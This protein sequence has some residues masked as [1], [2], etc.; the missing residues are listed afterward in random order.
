MT[1]AIHVLV[2]DD[3]ALFRNNM[4]KLLGLEEDL[5]ASAAASG[6]EALE[7]LRLNPCDVVLLDV[8]MPGLPAQEVLREMRE[9][10]CRAEVVVVTGH[11]SVDDAMEFIGGGAF[12]YLLKP[13]PIQEVVKKIRWA[14]ESLHKKAES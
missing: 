7:H 1:P 2:V 5:L 13:C 11:A 12:D 14:Y 8:K 10:G 4:V 3:E 6:D 9:M